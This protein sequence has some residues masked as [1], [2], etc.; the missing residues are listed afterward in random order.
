MFKKKIYGFEVID[1]ESRQ[2]EKTYM[3]YYLQ[4]DILRPIIQKFENPA[5]NED[6]LFFNDLKQYVIKNNIK[7]IITYSPHDSDTVCSSPYL[8]SSEFDFEECQSKG[9]WD[10]YI[11]SEIILNERE[12]RILKDNNI[13]IKLLNNKDRN[14]LEKKLKL[15]NE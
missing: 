14:N 9:I 13:R 3:L 1:V 10:R 7:Q 6:L 4:K 12:E 8:I 2:I 5:N 11:H 15:H